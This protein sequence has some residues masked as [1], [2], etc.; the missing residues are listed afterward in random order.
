MQLS[1]EGRAM[2]GVVRCRSPR[3]PMGRPELVS[4][5]HTRFSKQKSEATNS[6]LSFHQEVRIEQGDSS[7]EVEGSSDIQRKPTTS[8]PRRL[9]NEGNDTT[10][11]TRYCSCLSHS[12][13]GLS[14][15]LSLR[16]PLK[17]VLAQDGALNHL[18][19]IC[20]S[21]FLGVNRTWGDRATRLPSLRLI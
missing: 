1:R 21:L 16:H 11:S 17:G 12:D 2:L 19:G 6:N 4:L 13:V 7:N 3:G 14:R 9:H 10:N 5:G 18:H 20:D 15:G 8:P